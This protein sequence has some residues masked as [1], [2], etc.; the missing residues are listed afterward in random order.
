M[1]GQTIYLEDGDTFV[2]IAKTGITVSD[3]ADE[4]PYVAQAYRVVADRVGPTLALVAL[5]C[6]LATTVESAATTGV[7]AGLSVSAATAENDRARTRKVRIA[8]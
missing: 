2:I 5:A 7:R 6:P 8:G 1:A 4:F 3:P